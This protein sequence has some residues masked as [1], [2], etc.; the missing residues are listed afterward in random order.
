M[1]RGEGT[2]RNAPRLCR[3][4]E[5]EHKRGWLD[6]KP[7]ARNDHEPRKVDPL[8]ADSSYLARAPELDE[9]NEHEVRDY[10]YKREEA[11][12]TY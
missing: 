3:G 4:R 9:K 5:R 2:Y 8:K 11:S 7:L 10:S 12:R 6:G 1:G